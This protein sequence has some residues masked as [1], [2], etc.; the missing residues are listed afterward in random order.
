MPRHK[1]DTKRLTDQNGRG[2]AEKWKSLSPCLRR[3]LLRGMVSQEFLLIYSL[4]APAPDALVPADTLEF[5]RGGFSL[6]YRNNAILDITAQVEINRE[7]LKRL[8]IF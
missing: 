5:R 6:R 3:S 2:W 4:P 1:L 8:I 7:V